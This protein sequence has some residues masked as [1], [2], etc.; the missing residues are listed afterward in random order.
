MHYQNGEHNEM[1]V[2]I[3]NLFWRLDNAVPEVIRHYFVPVMR[4]SR[5]AIPSMPKKADHGF[6]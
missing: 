5:K 2:R 1:P 4:A 6:L 3:K